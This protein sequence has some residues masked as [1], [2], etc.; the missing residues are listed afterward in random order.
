MSTFTGILNV[1]AR[2]HHVTVYLDTHGGGRG[3]RCVAVSRV[4]GANVKLVILGRY[5]DGMR[6]CGFA[7]LRV[8]AGATRPREML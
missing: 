2:L 8:A 1:A 6:V 3:R 4:V 5:Q 7:G